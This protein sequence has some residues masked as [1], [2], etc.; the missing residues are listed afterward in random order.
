VV[1]A[2]CTNRDLPLFL[3]GDR[4]SFF[5]LSSGAPVDAVR[6]L[7]GPSAPHYETF[8]GESLWRLVNHLNLNY[9]S[10]TDE[11]GGSAA[12]REM[13]ELYARVG[14]P[15]LRREVNAIRAITSQSA[16]GPFPQP[17]PRTFVRGLEV[18]LHC[19]EQAFAHGALTLA[20]VLT[21]FFAKYAFTN[22][23]AQTVLHTVERGEVYRWPALPGLR[24]TF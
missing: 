6:C 4:Q 11:A 17:G 15:S 21:A 8:D 7:A 1:D 3:S 14:D 20:S 16:V 18:H 22:S 5:S 24:H 9:L 13:L 2:L 23:F 10:L 19:E 12:L